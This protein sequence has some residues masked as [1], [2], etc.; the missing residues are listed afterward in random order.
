MH[1]KFAVTL[2]AGH[3]DWL[4]GL[5]AM[6]IRARGQCMR[7]N[8]RKPGV[9]AVVKLR[10]FP[11][12]FSMAI[13]ALPAELAKVNILN[14]MTTAAGCRKPLVNFANVA[15]AAGHFSMC[16]TEWEFCVVMIECSSLG[17]RGGGVAGFALRT[18]ISKVW[19][20]FAMAG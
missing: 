10:R 9:L 1:I 2:E 20:L 5:F 12:F 17:P 7:T 3:G 11:G 6:A 4:G 18:E 19:I 8:Q 16:A 14:G 13:L 15:A